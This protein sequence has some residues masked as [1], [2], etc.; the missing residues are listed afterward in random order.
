MGR[1]GISAC[2]VAIA[3]LAWWF[4]G[5]AS[6]AHVPPA[7]DTAADASL[8]ARP[9][10]RAGPTLR[11]EAHVA[12]TATKALSNESAARPAAQAWRVL[13]A[14]EQEQDAGILLVGP[15]TPPPEFVDDGPDGERDRERAHGN[16]QLRWESEAPDPAGTD[17]MRARVADAIRDTGV[18][19]HAR[20]VQCRKTLCRLELHVPSI[21]E[22]QRFIELAGSSDEDLFI[23]VAP[24]AQPDQ[25]S[26]VYVSRPGYPF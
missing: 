8:P 14:R 3:A 11:S 25:A 16:V 5:R 6:P 23:E 19:I 22:G 9:V 21:E 20:A 24:S 15:A 7:P 17:S 18:D 26:V 4:A 2:C 13:A 1:R 10:G 12:P